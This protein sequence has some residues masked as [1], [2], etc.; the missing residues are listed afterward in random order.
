MPEP[1]LIG[2]PPQASA[3]GLDVAALICAVVLAPVGFVLGLVSR[4]SAMRRGL[5]PNVVATAAVVVGS[6]IMGLAALIVLAPFL[7]VTAFFGS[8]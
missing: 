1:S 8:A 6:I 3:S 4:S 5:R 2:T 7:M